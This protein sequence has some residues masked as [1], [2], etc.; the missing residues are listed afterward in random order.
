MIVLIWLLLLFGL[1]LT[2]AY[3]RM[4]LPIITGFVCLYIILLW[5]TGPFTLLGDVLFTVP[6][7]GVALVLNVRFLRCRLI[8]SKLLSY[9]LKRKPTLSDTEKQAVRLGTPGWEAEIFSGKPNWKRLHAYPALQLTPR[10]QKFLDEDTEALCALL[11]NWDISHHRRALPES[12]LNFIKTRG[13]WSF[14]IPKAYGGLEFSA[15]AQAQILMK[16]ASC[17]NTAATMVGVPNS[18]GPA[19]LLLKYGT[20]KQKN[21]YLPRLATGEEIPCFALTSP[22]S[23]SDAGAMHDSGIVC[24]DNW[25]GKTVLGIRLNW[26]KR[27][28]TLAPIA[29]LLGLAFKLY[30]PDHLLGEKKAYGITCALIPT[31]LSGIRIGRRHF[32]ANCAFPNGPT[33]G[34]SV[35]IPIDHIIG[36]PDMAGKGWQMLME[37]LAVGRC[38]TLPSLSVGMAKMATGTTTAYACL[39]KQFHVSIANF[40]GIKSVLARMIGNTYMM[41]ATRLLGVSAVVKGEQPT[42]GSAISKY[43]TTEI[44]RQVISDA[45]DVHG[46][47]GICMGPSNYLAQ[48][49]METPIGITVEGSNIITRSMIIFGQGL[50]RSHPY[51]LA[52]YR[53]CQDPDPKKALQS[54]DKILFQHIGFFISNRVR[55]LLL[56]LT[57]GRLAQSF[58][59]THP[60]QKR[61]YQ[62]I[63]RFSAAFAHLADISALVLGAKLKKYEHLSGHLA[64][65]LGALYM[66]G[67]LL[68]YF[69]DA[70]SKAADL[71]L[72]AWGCQTLLFKAQTAL[73]LAL[74]NFPNPLVR[75]LLRPIIF[76]LG[77][78][79][80]PPRDALSDQVA[81]LLSQDNKTRA[82]LVS[83]IYNSPDT[84]N[85]VGK[86]EVV[87]KQFVASWAIEHKIKAAF[88]KQDL[89]AKSW[90]A[91]L[92]ESVERNIITPDEKTQ[93]SNIK[94]AIVGLMRVDDFK[95]EE[96]LGRWQEP[97]K[98][99]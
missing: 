44:G 47:K 5:Y 68:K 69:S 24:K 90:A 71:P 13:F 34:K 36:G 65:V 4:P 81:L 20:E 8:T 98:L 39:R 58:P 77:R 49:Y 32:P 88:S 79:L 12:V 50:M 28:I 42:I 57:G 54:F 14:I 91:I 55:T 61:Y 45:M 35:F 52:E 26:D 99:A 1:L 59:L 63:T 89:R 95:D 19:E 22:S 40:E 48:M 46:G 27:Y 53:A 56:G 66:S 43:Y 94:Q 83:G 18:L 97:A 41:D 67:A 25:K 2:C 64:D 38:I 60:A 30:D 16:I 23:G 15:F 62:Q 92:T 21:D 70:G 17:S 10:E 29:T 3:L 86:Q 9:Y 78:T 75:R 96:L 93:L 31:H 11:D 37:C 84:N 76:P 87:F 73:D 6:I 74:V 85:L 80:R 7:G 51:L 33:Q 82:R 72:M